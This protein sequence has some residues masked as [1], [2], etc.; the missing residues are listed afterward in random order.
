MLMA[1]A[2]H[3]A[4]HGAGW[5]LSALSPL[6]PQKFEV[7][8]DGVAVGPSCSRAGWGISTHFCSEVHGVEEEAAGQQQRL[9]LA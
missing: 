5:G 9:S 8:G 2:G 7:L 1:A 4:Q 3:L 6:D